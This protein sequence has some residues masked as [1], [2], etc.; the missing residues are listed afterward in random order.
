[1]RPFD[2]FKT[3][4]V[5]TA[6]LVGVAMLTVPGRPG[7]LVPWLVTGF[8]ALVAAADFFEARADRKA[9]NEDGDER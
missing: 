4:T 8:I 3:I 5:C 6:M 1:M 9:D 7:P 2:I